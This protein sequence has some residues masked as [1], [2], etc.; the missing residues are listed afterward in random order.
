MYSSFYDAKRKAAALV[1]T[2]KSNTFTEPNYF[3]NIND[4]IVFETVREFSLSTKAIQCTLTDPTMRRNST[5]VYYMYDKNMTVCSVAT[6]Q[7]E[8]QL[9]IDTDGT[10]WDWFATEDYVYILIDQCVVQMSTA[11]YSTTTITPSYVPDGAYNIQATDDA[12][13]LLTGSGMYLYDV[14]G[15]YLGSGGVSSHGQ[16]NMILMGDEVWSSVSFTKGVFELSHCAVSDTLD[17]FP[18]KNIAVDG[19]SNGRLCVYDDTHLILSGS[20]NQYI[21]FDTTDHSYTTHTM[22]S[23]SAYFTRPYDEDGV[24]AFNG[25]GYERIK[26]GV[27]TLFYETLDTDVYTY[28]HY[29]YI[30]GIPNAFTDTTTLTEA[31]FVDKPTGESSAHFTELQCPSLMREIERMIEAQT[32]ASLRGSTN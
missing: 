21:L 26:G 9:G 17:P 6:G 14:T 32:Q 1:S 10:C 3:T 11:D 19:L 20:P 31:S 13:A 24:I 27:R 7:Q 4:T 29:G 28:P 30:T 8:K 16:G 25:S 5:H 18:N 23:Y 22:E 2:T 12:F 15:Q